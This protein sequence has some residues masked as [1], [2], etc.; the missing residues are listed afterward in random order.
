MKCRIT[1]SLAITLVATAA[2]SGTDQNATAADS[3]FSALKSPHPAVTRVPQNASSYS[4]F[5]TLQTRPLALSP[6]G[7][8]LFVANT[9]DDRLEIFRVSRQHL[10]PV[11]SV[12]VGLEPIALAVRGDDEIWVV[13]HLSDSISIV[14]VRNPAAP[15]VKRTLLVGDEPRDVV[16][17]GPHRDRAFVTTAHRGQNSPD[18]PELFG[19]GIGRADVWVFDAKNLGS[20]AAGQRLTKITLFADSPR[21]LAVTP[22]GR[23][24][25]AAAFMSGNQTTAIA[26]ET[27]TA[28]YGGSMPGPASITFQ[29]QT[30]PQPVTGEIVKFKAGPDGVSH[31]VDAYGTSFDA[32]VKITMPDQDVFAIDATANPP[33][34]VADQTFAHV[35]T[36]LFNMAV[37][38]KSGKVYV[39]NT[40]AHNDVR[41]EGHNAGFTSVLGNAVDSRITVL[42]PRNKSVSPHNLNPHID[43]DQDVGDASLSVALPLELA[44]SANGRKLFVAAQGSSKLA[45][46]DTAELE[47]DH[48]RPSAATQVSLSGGGPTGLVLD[49]S[50]GVAFALTRFD[51]AVSV[52]D[53]ATL[54]EVGHVKL[55]NPEPAIVTKGRPFLYDA[56]RTSKHGDQACASCHI[57]GDLDALAWDLGNPGAI[58]LPISKLAASETVIQVVPPERLVP[59]LGANAVNG[60]F[61][62]IQPLKGPMTT[63]SLRGLDNH[64]AMH[65]RGDRNGAVQQTGLPFTD[66][67]GQPVV[68][69]QPSFGMFDEVN[70]FKSFNVAFPG[71]VGLA[72]ELS[73]AEMS[74]FADFALELT[75]PPNPIRNLDNSLTALQE[76]GRSFF[77]NTRE[78]GT[79]A[80]SDGIHNCNGCHVLDRTANAGATRHPGFFGSDGRITFEGETQL[81]KIAHLR[82]AYQK[83][84]MYASPPTP[85]ALATLIPQLNNSVTPSPAVRGFGYLHDGSIGTIEQFLSG[86]VFAQ[87]TQLSVT[88][89]VILPP[90]PAGIPVFN[91]PTAPLDP[92]SGISEQ[93]LAL[94]RALASFVLAFD[95]NMAPVVGQQV[96]LTRDNA[97]SAGPRIDLLE[98]RASA[99]ECDLV[100]HA[101]IAGREAGLFLWQGSYV[102]D[103]TGL[104]ALARASLRGAVGTITDAVTFTCVPP[105]A[106]WRIGVDRDGDG[107]ANGDE[108]LAR[109][110][111]EDAQSTP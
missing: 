100:A 99:G 29:G 22:D 40:E 68:S 2:C 15:L 83:L 94:R 89:G 16:F 93:G 55:F 58:P 95:S 107:Y 36:A 77:F 75:Y 30:I 85:R 19:A 76:A 62:A 81:F 56:T 4:L 53:L 41:F 20:S 17:A 27:V 3:E 21:A 79:E 57:G 111:L 13:N 6:D 18:D 25:Y 65:W 35:G 110:N 44:V 47:A 67:S 48:T 105:G 98:A 97:T 50:E 90:N 52:I 86:I 69:A 59:L 103:E 51:D 7:K 106:G 10:E 43:H 87:A 46:Y 73:D 96:T 64:G 31:W 71:L 38:P 5:E 72:E 78:D 33:V 42:D 12:A 26:G 84:G 37:N 92:S 34:A 80:P 45:V 11:G 91:D 60:L 1:L 14:D 39:S 28:A 82:N 49:E 8:L 109:S 23:T 102:R 88:N 74:A 32:A 66:A 104:V 101:R 9:P 54:R 70:A 24:V 63:Q 108:L 61:A